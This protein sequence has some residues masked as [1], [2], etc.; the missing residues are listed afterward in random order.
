MGIE[1]AFAKRSL[2]RPKHTVQPARIRRTK[3]ASVSQNPGPGF[4]LGRADPLARSPIW[5]LTKAKRA[6]SMANAIRV[7]KAA[8][9]EVREEK[10][11]TVVWVE[12]ERRKAINVTAVATGWT[13]SPRVHEAPIVVVDL[14]SG[15][16]TA[17][18]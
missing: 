4:V 13:A 1:V 2:R 10:R 6:M 7:R 15:L 17:T 3:V 16:R 11:V 8:R 14:R 5:S 9:K 12:N 18:V